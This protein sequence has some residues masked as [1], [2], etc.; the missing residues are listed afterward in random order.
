MTASAS[1]PLADLSRHH[2]MALQTRKRDGTWVTT[3]VNPLVEG[4]HVYFR[5]WHTSGKAKRLRNFADVRF[6]PSTA[7]GRPTGPWMRGQATLLEEDDAAHAAALIN[8][9]YPLLQGV[10]VRLF[11]RLR[12]Y[13]TLHYRITDISAAAD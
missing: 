12:R 6:A 9:R 1:T 11:H 13:R 4:D 3:A 7:R 10:A 2:D 8:R 5:T